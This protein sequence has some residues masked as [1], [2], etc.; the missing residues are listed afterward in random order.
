MDLASNMETRD[1]HGTADL[2]HCCFGICL[3]LANMATLAA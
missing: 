1:D 3:R 2:L